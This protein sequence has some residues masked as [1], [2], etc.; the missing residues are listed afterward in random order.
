MLD[1][2]PQ[3]DR[4]LPKSEDKVR[5]KELAYYENKFG[6]DATP[7]E[8]QKI[9]LAELTTE[10]TDIHEMVSTAEAIFTFS[11]SIS[12]M[13]DLDANV[14]LQ[15]LSERASKYPLP[16]V[17]LEAYEDS[18]RNMGL[19]N[20][21][22]QWAGQAVVAAYKI[23]G[24]TLKRT[25]IFLSRSKKTVDGLDNRLT[26]LT[27]LM[28]KRK[29]EDNRIFFPKNKLVLFVDEY[30]VN[31]TPAS[32]VGSFVATIYGILDD[33]MDL[34]RTVVVEADRDLSKGE[35]EK[36]SVEDYEQKVKD[37]LDKL[38]ERFKDK[39]LLIGNRYIKINKNAKL[40][41]AVTLEVGRPDPKTI[42]GKY[43]PMKALSN[44]QVESQRDTLRSSVIKKMYKLLDETSEEMEKMSKFK[45]LST[46][47]GK[48]DV[49][50]PDKKDVATL[51]KFLTDATKELIEGIIVLSD[52]V[53]ETV[54]ATITLLED[55]VTVTQIMTED[56]DKVARN[57][58]RLV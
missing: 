1:L 54:D 16:D 42:I 51:S 48:K 47:K 34:L 50:T 18:D 31:T 40:S 37:L 20:S 10:S 30:E 33:Y 49:E 36:L 55:S 12:E 29:S 15:M 7:E 32:A 3:E 26:K 45:G 38:D 13:D 52:M 23:L 6:K 56:D 57:V 21:L 5:E 39:D 28:D 14:A 44:S 24:Y 22:I 41:K 25:G 46:K 9:L 35:G 4:N 43:R 19:L 2:N 27:A 8:E 17:T 53:Y 11:P 58:S